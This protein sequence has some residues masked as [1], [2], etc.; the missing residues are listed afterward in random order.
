MDQHWCPVILQLLGY[1]VQTSA[2]G[3]SRVLH[4]FFAA[5]SP[6]RALIARI[7]KGHDSAGQLK[8]NF[9]GYLVC[10]GKSSLVL[11]LVALLVAHVFCKSK[12]LIPCGSWR[13]QHMG[14]KFLSELSRLRQI[15]DEIQFST[16][17]CDASADTR[18]LR[19]SD[20]VR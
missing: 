14:W 17:Q 13:P 8:A 1:G 11:T 3:L 7:W 18:A 12:Y 4:R 19:Q 10:S 9:A 5:L 6:D 16:S 2:G 20:T 15:R